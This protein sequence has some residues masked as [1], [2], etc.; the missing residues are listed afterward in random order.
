MAVMTKTTGEFKSSNERSTVKYYVY[1]PD[2]N[3]RAVVQIVHGMTEHFGCYDAV[4]TYLCNHGFVVVGHDQ[5]G[6]GCTAADDDDLGYFADNDGDKYVVA[7]VGILRDIMKAKYRSL[8]YI[9]IGHSFGSFV[10]RAYVA[11]H[12]DAVD[13]FILSGTNGKKMPVG[14]AR[15]LCKTIM[16]FK[17]KHHRSMLVSALAFGSYN[18]KFGNKFGYDWVSSDPEKIKKYSG[19]KF[20]TFM[21]TLQAYYDMFTI[22]RFIQSDEWYDMMPKS[23][24]IFVIAGEDD[25][26]GFYTKGVME[27]LE[28]LHERDLTDLEYK[29]YEGE[30]HELFTGLR[31]E[32]AFADVAQWI[33]E[34]IEGIIEARTL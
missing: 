34:R 21:F 8:P 2:D 26:V 14:L 18:K 1:T 31:K 4:A 22:I 20:C 7:D 16:C 23:L 9:L 15:F 3:P 13:A 30:R 29:I 10:T 28:K 17:G 32:E 25:P 19:D 24:P 33:D 6:H 5:I 12:P 27:M 11:T